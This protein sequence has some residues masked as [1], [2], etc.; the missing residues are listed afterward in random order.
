MEQLIGPIMEQVKAFLYIQMAGDAVK[1]KVLHPVKQAQDEVKDN[2]AEGEGASPTQQA[3]EEPGMPDEF[4]QL[5]AIIYLL[6]KVRNFRYIMKYFPHEVKDLEPVVNYL[7]TQRN[8]QIIIW[9]SKYILLLW[10][11]VIIL[12]PFDLSTIDSRYIQIDKESGDDIVTNLIEVSKFYLRS[13]T[14]TRDAAA[15][16]LS[17]FFTRPDIQ[18]LNVI[19]G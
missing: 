8:N 14:K 3:K 19:D 5:L 6:C 18:K 2:A 17:Q 16:V 11:S 13:S 7:V 15:I 12:V 9:E 1:H 10:L 4:H